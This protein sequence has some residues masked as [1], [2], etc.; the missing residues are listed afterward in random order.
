MSFIH[1]LFIGHFE[2]DDGRVRFAK[3]SNDSP[4]RPIVSRPLDV[5]AIKALLPGA[6]PSTSDDLTFPTDWSS[7]LEGDGWLICDKY[8]GNEGEINFVAQ[9][10]DQTG[11]EI[12]DFSAHT[13]LAPQEWLAERHADLKW[14]AEGRAELKREPAVLQ[15]E[16]QDR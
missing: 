6:C 2:H 3:R 13:T 4:F 5:G 8:T 14:R 10:C 15:S 7:W 1:Y 16:G 12:Y 9:L 11:C